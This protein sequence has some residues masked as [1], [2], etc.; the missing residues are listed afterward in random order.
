MVR[1][2]PELRPP[3]ARPRPPQ[4]P[5]RALANMTARNAA[6]YA[7]AKA[8]CKGARSSVANAEKSAPPSRT[9]CAST[10]CATRRRQGQRGER[11]VQHLVEPRRQQHAQRRDRQ[12]PRRS[13]H[14]V[15]DPGSDARVPRIDG[16]HDR[17]RER[18]DGQPH[19]GAQRQHAREERASSSCRPPTG[20]PAAGSRRPPPAGRTPEEDAGRPSRPARRPSGSSPTPAPRTAA[21]PRRPQPGCSPA[22]G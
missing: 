19:P 16:A 22:P 15:V 1:V 11:R 12:Q 5:A 4:P 8:A 9:R 2:P 20:G 6:T 18:R 14:R 21:A 13:R 3:P 10:A 7:V 17:R